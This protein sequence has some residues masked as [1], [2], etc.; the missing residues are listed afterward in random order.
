MSST[1]AAGPDTSLWDL[2]TPEPEPE[3]EPEPLPEPEVET[4]EDVTSC[5]PAATECGS[6]EEIASATE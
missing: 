6:E 2:P 3:P 4:L 1:A 5:D